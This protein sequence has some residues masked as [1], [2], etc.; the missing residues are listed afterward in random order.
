[1]QRGNLKCSATSCAHNQS[2]ECKAG[3]IHVSGRGAVAIEGTSCTTFVDRDSTSFVNSLAGDVRE[4][5]S[6]F[7]SSNSSFVNSAG[8]STTEPCNIKCEAHNC[9]FNKNKE[10]Y[11]ENVQ[12]DACNAYCKSFEYGEYN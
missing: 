11:V 12:I 5:E 1:M 8:D 3:N 10:C 9:R 7:N 4:K 2:Y 6:F